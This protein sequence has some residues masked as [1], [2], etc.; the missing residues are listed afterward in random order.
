MIKWIAFEG[1]KQNLDIQKCKITDYNIN[2]HNEKQ[3]HQDSFHRKPGDT[4]V[5]TDVKTVYEY[6]KEKMNI[7]SK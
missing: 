6:L 4:D 5:K 2:R 7:M 1:S 3:N